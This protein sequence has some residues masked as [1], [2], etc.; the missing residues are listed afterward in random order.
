MDLQERITFM[1]EEDSE[2]EKEVR[3]IY[4]TLSKY[5]KME[6]I[7][8]LK[9]AVWRTSC[10]NVKFD[11]MQEIEAFDPAE[12]KRERRIKSGVNAIIQNV[13]PFLK[14]PFDW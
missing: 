5:E 10:L 1:T 3:E 9:L 12:F 11:S 14:E 4:E 8:L 2:K 7:S 13:L 6:R